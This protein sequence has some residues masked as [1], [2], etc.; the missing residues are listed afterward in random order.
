MS[1]GL[2]TALVLVLVVGAGVLGYELYQEKSSKSGIEISV[3]DRGVS[4]KEK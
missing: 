2:L 4:I 3:G 1:K